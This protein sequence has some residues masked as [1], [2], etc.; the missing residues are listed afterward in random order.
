[1][2][3]TTQILDSSR[4]SI[5]DAIDQAFEAVWRMLYAHMPPEN[6]Q[7]MGVENRT[8]PNAHRLGRLLV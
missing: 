2:S 1:M 7:S 4:Q 8:Q 6:E 5:V 3:V